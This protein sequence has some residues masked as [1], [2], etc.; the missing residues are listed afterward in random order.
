ML[1]IATTFTV[2][3]NSGKNVLVRWLGQRMRTFLTLFENIK[4]MYTQLI[5][6]KLTFF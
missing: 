3:I 4:Y 6:S 1:G 5:L 2:C